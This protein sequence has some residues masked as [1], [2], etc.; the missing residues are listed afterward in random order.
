MRLFKTYSHTLTMRGYEASG[1]MLHRRKTKTKNGRR[2]KS[3]RKLQNGGIY[4]R[5]SCHF[6]RLAREMGPEKRGNGNYAEM[7]KQKQKA[8]ALGSRKSP[9]P[10]E[11]SP[12]RSRKTCQN[13]LRNKPNSRA[14]NGHRA[15]P[16]GGEVE[17][18]R[19]ITGKIPPG[20]LNK[21]PRTTTIVSRKRKIQNGENRSK[22]STAV[23]A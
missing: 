23:V 18:G 9:T 16:C 15:S 10:R 2:E 5:D 21:K 6:R 11:Q 12:K 7:Q 3:C 13:A 20:K 8:K 22:Y 19:G 1:I 4:R 14:Q 17:T